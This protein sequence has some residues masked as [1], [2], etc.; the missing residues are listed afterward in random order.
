MHETVAYLIAREA[1]EPFLV[2]HLSLYSADGLR[3]LDMATGPGSE[4]QP[5]RL[6][7]GTLVSTAHILQDLQGNFG[8]FFV[9]PDV[10][11]RWRGSFQL[12]VTLMKLSRQIS[13]RITGYHIAEYLRRTDSSLGH[14]GESG[15]TLAHARTRPFDVLP[16]HEYT[17]ARKT[18]TP[19]LCQHLILTAWP[20]QRLG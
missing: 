16:F 5:R 20:Q 10:S 3:P 2:A 1:E 11:I 8:L 19:P 13:S 17:A 9:F 14:Q 15:T 12:G 7:Y 6:L 18:F 4:D